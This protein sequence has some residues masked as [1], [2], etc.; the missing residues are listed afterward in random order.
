MLNIRFTIL[1]MR[2]VAD[3]SKLCGVEASLPRQD[4]SPASAVPISAV[5]NDTATSASA[6]CGRIHFHRRNKKLIGK[7][8]IFFTILFFSATIFCLEGCQPIPDT[9]IE[10]DGRRYGVVPSFSGEW[11]HHYERGL[12]FADGALWKEAE[13][14]LREA[15]RQ[16]EADQKRRA[17]TYGRHFFESSYHEEGYFPHRELGIVLYHQ[18]RIKEAID[19]LEISLAS[20]K[21]S[22]A[23]TYLDRAR[24][25]LIE[26]DGF[27]R[28][29]PE[30]A[31]TSPEQN[32]LTNASFVTIRGVAKD[33]TYV[34]SITVGGKK[35]RVDVSNQ[36]ISFLM[37]VPV[38]PGKNEIPVLAKDLIGK[39][40]KSSVTVNV[41][42]MGPVISVE[43][44]FEE[45]PVYETG[46]VEL[47]GYVF[48]KSGLTE[49]M[50]NGIKTDCNGQQE[51]RFGKQV[52][53]GE[54]QRRLEIRAEDMA[55]NVTS[56]DIIL[57]D[58][59][60]V[61]SSW[62]A[63]NGN[64][65]FANILLSQ[66]Q[67]AELNQIV[68]EK[69]KDEHK[70]Y[71]TY[72]KEILINGTIKVRGSE[73]MTRLW[74]NQDEG[75]F[76]V[77]NRSTCDF[78]YIYP[79]EIGNI[80]ILA[81]DASGGEISRREIR[82]IRKDSDTL[83]GQR[84][85]AEIMAFKEFPKDLY[86]GFEDS[87]DTVM[88]EGERFRVITEEEDMEADCMIRGKFRKRPGYVEASANLYLYELGKDKKS[89]I[90]L[91][92]ANAYR[93]Y[94]NEIGRDVITELAKEIH[95]KLAYDV[96]LIDGTV[97]ETDGTKKVVTDLGKEMQIK[98]GMEIVVYQDPPK[99]ED[100][101]EVL[102]QARINAV[103]KQTSSAFLKE[104]K[105]PIQKGQP[106]ITR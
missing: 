85:G 31:L 77:K 89:K 58:R 80:I 13:L 32:F 4:I 100:D 70:T 9:G 3:R 73:A 45:Q 62:V 44:P 5:T 78:S 51:I 96:P 76:R 59:E 64:I 61:R 53:I 49:I 10:K 106:V 69:F 20:V 75:S 99:I 26:Q 95:W 11:W 2:M 90:R 35:V 94:E 65:A 55:G 72:L 34:R 37:R 33:D 14:D 97:T 42:R 82:I 23:E 22:R 19:E 6:L 102:G 17:R 79:L 86:L 101:Y 56:S 7:A 50:I 15:V 67:S 74:F 43:E 28:R 46:L 47:K 24:K 87:L 84:L 93:E 88:L 60:A 57:S 39:E 36:E 92:K 27:D 21:S 52:K 1:Y 105:K 48:D 81:E 104:P 54:K 71:V 38:I 12:S 66:Q 40:G 63:E 103:K 30:I 18:R 25:I 98:K 41:D 91:A 29:P 83:R 8:T 16:R 68:L